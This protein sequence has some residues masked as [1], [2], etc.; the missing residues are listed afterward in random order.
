MAKDPFDPTEAVFAGFIGGIVG[1][2]LIIFILGLWRVMHTMTGDYVIS[3]ILW[4]IV[5]AATVVGAFLGCVLYDIICTKERLEMK[6]REN[7][8]AQKG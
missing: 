1:M 3:T 5:L 2:G 4:L 7:G 6:E 8:K